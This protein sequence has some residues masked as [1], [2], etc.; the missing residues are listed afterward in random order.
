MLSTRPVSARFMGARGG[1]T[2]F[3]VDYED[4]GV[5]L[6]DP[7]QGLLYQRWRARLENAGE[8]QSFVRLDAP[9]VPE[10]VWLTVPYMEQISFTFDASMQPV[11]CYVAQG[12]AYMNWYDNQSNQYVTTMLAADVVNP[13]VSLDD[14]RYLGSNGY[15]FS[16]VILAYTRGGNLYYRQ[17]R[18]RYTVERLLANNVKPLI[19]IGM[20]RQ[21]RMQFM[22][23]V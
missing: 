1:A 7:S 23:E 12:R 22:S 2:S 16:D 4:G 18:E 6:N 3:T 5:A 13:R 17:Q 10:F 15:Q 21:L 11:V 8:P 14:K 19:R 20:N 9:Q